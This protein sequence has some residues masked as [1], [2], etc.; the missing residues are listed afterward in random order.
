MNSKWALFFGL[1]LLAS[2]CA[3]IQNG[4]T[5]ASN[6]SPQKTST[7]SPTNATQAFDPAA[8]GAMPVGSST[9]SLDGLKADAEKGNANAQVALGLM[10]ESG[11][12]VAQNDRN[13][14]EAVTWYQKA[15]NQGNAN[16]Q[17]DLA[18]CYY[19]GEG[20]SQD[21]AE[22]I[23][24]YQKAAEQGNVRAQD[25]LGHMYQN[26][27]GTAQ[28]Y[29]EAMK[30]YQAAAG[31]GYA[32]AQ[33]DLGFMYE[34]GEGVP[35]NFDEAFNWYVRAAGQGNAVAQNN[36]GWMNEKGLG[37]TQ[38]NVEAVKWYQ[39]AAERGY[40]AAQVNLGFMYEN[41]EGTTQDRVEA[42]F[43]YGLAADQGQTNAVGNL[44]S[45]ESSMAQVQIAVAQC[46]IGNYYYDKN[47]AQ[48]VK[49]FQKSTDQNLAKAQEMLGTCYYF[50]NGVAQDY[51]VAAMWWRKASDQGLAEAQCLLGTSYERGLGVARDGVEA[52]KLYLTAADQGY[53]VA[54][55]NLG[56]C[57]L[58]GDGVPEDYV[59][60]YKWIDIA[61][62]QGLNEAKQDLPTLNASMLPQ[63]VAEAQQLASQFE[64]QQVSEPDTPISGNDS[65]S[66]P[67]ATGTGFFITDDGYLITNN[68]VVKNANKV[69]LLTTAGTIDAKVVQVD[70][71]NDIA[72]LKADGQFA[73]LPVAPSRTVALGNTVATVGFPDPELQG[74]SPKLAK[75]EISSLSGAADDA[76]YFQISVPVQPGNSGGALVDEYGNVVG[77]VAAKLDEATALAASGALPEN[78]NYAIKSGFILSFLESVPDVDAKLKAPNTKDEK[79]QDVVK[80]TEAATA[81]VLVY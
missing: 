62:G 30:W 14:I 26:G 6:Y 7:V 22:A 78:V 56:H 24:W 34:K 35:T 4:N 16:A 37:M 66:N 67:T 75:G 5:G 42:Y 32:P 59:Q 47:P 33:V 12:G 81:L 70:Q 80:D 60:A 71:A 63:Q 17:T 68:H 23:E 39:K 76:R 50:G 79:F 53:S 10:Y 3:T 21:Y 69:R 57:Y 45:L 18:Y 54:Q 38:N 44:Q 55:Y 52:A 29:G 64:P 43:W 9:T 65:A 72:L 73:A 77:I 61:A 13:Y 19:S 36:L 40:S 28:N 46:K 58:R 74:F 15:A 27:E 1:I 20:L 41:G 2:G 48:A 11:T 25:S 31:Q 51:A 49:W 8:L